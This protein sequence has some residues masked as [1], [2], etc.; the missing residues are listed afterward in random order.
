MNELKYPY[1]IVRANLESALA[2]LNLPYK[3]AIDWQLI[4]IIQKA[5]ELLENK[6]F[7]HPILDT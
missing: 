6:Y 3:D 2:K 5:N 4:N 7:Q 1:N